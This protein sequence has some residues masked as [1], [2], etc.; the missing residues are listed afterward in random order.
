MPGTGEGRPPGELLGARCPPE[1]AAGRGAPGGGVL[2]LGGL[3]LPG[4]PQEK[5]C[6]GGGGSALGIWGS[7]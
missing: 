2:G 6:V 5:P 1:A 7:A 4:V 3:L